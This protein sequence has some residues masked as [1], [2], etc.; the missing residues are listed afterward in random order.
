MAVALLIA[1]SCSD[2]TP[3]ETGFTIVGALRQIPASAADVSATEAVFVAADL[4]AAGERAGLTRPGATTDPE[5]LVAFFGPLIGAPS[6]DRPLRV[7]VPLPPVFETGIVG[8]AGEFVDEFGFSLGE[9]TSFAAVEAGRAQFVTVSGVAL[10]PELPEVAPGVST[11][12]EG[13]DYELGERA[14]GRP[15]GRPLRLA[16]QDDRVAVSLATPPVI[17]WLTEP[18]G[19]TLAD[20]PAFAALGARLDEE[21]VVS[22]QLILLE[23]QPFLGAGFGWSAD[24]VGARSTIVF[25]YESAGA[26]EADFA[27][28]EAAFYGEDPY[29]E[30]LDDRL[31]VELIELREGEI[32]AVVRFLDD[33]HPSF[34][35]RLL[36]T[37]PPA[38]EGD[39]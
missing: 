20:D 6:A 31:T 13:E 27:R 24:D 30:L 32:V 3:D 37:E 33:L 28:I 11:V 4:V 18:D 1:A 16:Q 10:A 25:G 35:Q 7:F 38:L 12:G 26:A 15:L 8:Q 34:S 17:D 14:P 2:A 21:A 22:A 39:G 23:G 36:F 9:A 5:E 19:A 29:G